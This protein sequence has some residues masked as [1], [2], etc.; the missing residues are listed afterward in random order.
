MGKITFLDN[1]EA[2]FDG[3]ERERYEQVA[4]AVLYHLWRRLPFN[5]RQRLLDVLPKDLGDLVTEPKNPNEPATAV[6]QRFKEGPVES[7]DIRG[8]LEQIRQETGLGEDNEDQEAI[9]AVFKALK[10]ELPEYEVTQ[11]REVLPTGVKPMW[12]GA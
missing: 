12:A 10:A 4:H 7:D 1:F 11:I 3:L 8:F 2:A 6:E 5:E 9:R